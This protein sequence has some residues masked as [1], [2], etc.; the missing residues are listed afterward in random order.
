MFI[1]PHKNQVPAVGDGD[2]ARQAQ[3]QP[4]ALGF[5]ATGFGTPEETLE[6]PFLVLPANQGTGMVAAGP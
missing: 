2:L 4:G 3:A 1:A 5:A 6:N